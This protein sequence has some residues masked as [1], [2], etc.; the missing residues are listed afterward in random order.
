MRLGRL[1][2]PARFA[3]HACPG[4][5]LGQAASPQNAPR[6][7]QAA[8][9][10]SVNRRAKDRLSISGNPGCNTTRPGAVTPSRP[11]CRIQALPRR[12]FRVSPYE[13]L[14]A[15]ARRLETMHVF[16]PRRD[17]AFPQSAPPPL[18]RTRSIRIASACCAVATRTNRSGPRYP[19][20]GTS[21]RRQL[22]MSQASHPS[23]LADDDRKGKPGAN[24]GRKATGLGAS[25]HSS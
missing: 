14:L 24:R 10:T 25:T 11:G 17:H 7:V 19:K 20:A 4:L 18:R 2:T 8:H 15:P 23:A 12:R 21:N 22:L 3:Q 1:A 6:T 5:G 16:V 9:Q 13:R